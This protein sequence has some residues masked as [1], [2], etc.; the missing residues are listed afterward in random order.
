[1][2]TMKKKCPKEGKKKGGGEIFM[3]ERK[4]EQL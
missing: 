1:M 2:K 4:K 3:L